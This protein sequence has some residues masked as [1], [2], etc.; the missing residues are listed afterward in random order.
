[1]LAELFERFPR[2]TVR[3][4]LA[5]YRGKEGFELHFPATAYVNVGSQMQ[6]A[7]MP[8]L[9]DCWGGSTMTVLYWLQSRLSR[10]YAQGRGR[11]LLLHTPWRAYRCHR[12]PLGVTL[13]EE[14]GAQDRATG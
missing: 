8:S 2:A 14:G 9:C 10:C 12:T 3:T 1:M 11:R 4:A 6:P 5:V 7:Y 13:T